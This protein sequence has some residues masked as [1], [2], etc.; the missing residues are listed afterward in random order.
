MKTM[1][2]KFEM[3]VL[4]NFLYKLAV[5]ESAKFDKTFNQKVK[6]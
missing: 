3:I 2:T 5:E 1:C 6:K 4:E